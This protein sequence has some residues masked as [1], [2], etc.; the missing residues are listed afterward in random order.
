MAM[1]STA[2]PFLARIMSGAK[3]FFSK[4]IAT[5]IGQPMY[6]HPCKHLYFSCISKHA[7][8]R[9]GAATRTPCARVRAHART[10]ARAHVRTRT[11]TRTN[12]L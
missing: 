9:A 4:S 6:L 8:S 1:G 5:V 11:R 12:T 7:R 10:H 3:P 2:I